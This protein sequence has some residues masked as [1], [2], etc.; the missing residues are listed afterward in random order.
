MRKKTTPTPIAR[1]MSDKN[2]AQRLDE[3]VQAA[4]CGDREAFGQ[5]VRRFRPRIFALALHLTANV[6]DAE[7]VAQDAF[8]R[9]FH[10]IGEFEGRSAFFTWLYRI[11]INRA[12]S[13][14]GQ[15][16]RRT[17][18]PLGDERVRLAVLADA[19]DDPFLAMELRETYTAL[20]QAL[21]QL[22][23]VLRATIV[24]TTLQGFSNREAAVIFGVSEGTVGW[25]VHEARAQLRRALAASEDNRAL[26]KR[27]DGDEAPVR[28][29]LWDLLHL[30]SIIPKAMPN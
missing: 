19:G 15:R 26:E 25:R 6:A 27:R 11:A 4:R 3:L 17:A 29:D 5:L 28:G 8:L 1:S 12:L 2:S 14:L 13:L 22:S 24:L 18:T 30:D 10:K 16:C 21:D 7:D 9:A 23:P 20:M